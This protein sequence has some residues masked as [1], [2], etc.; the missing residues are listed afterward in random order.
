M[1]QLLKGCNLTGSQIN[2]SITSKFGAYHAASTIQGQTIRYT[3]CLMINKGKYSKD[4]YKDFLEFFE[5]VA[6]A[7]SK[8]IALKSVQ[9]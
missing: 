9:N 5:K 1:M 8:K 3:R 7:D 2:H 6:N 4:A